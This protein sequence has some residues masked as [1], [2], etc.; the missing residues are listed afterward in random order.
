MNILFRSWNLNLS[1]VEFGCDNFD[2]FCVNFCK[3]ISLL[4]CT[5][6]LYLYML[7]HNIPVL[8]IMLWCTP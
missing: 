2:G 5:V 4:L 1:L 8:G 3:L 6:A 7:H